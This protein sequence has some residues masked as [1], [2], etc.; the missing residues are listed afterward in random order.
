MLLKAIF[1]INRYVLSTADY[2]RVLLVSQISV[3]FIFAMTLFTL[4][5]VVSGYDRPL[6]YNLFAI[7]SG[8]VVLILNRQGYFTSAMVVLTIAVQ[9]V[10]MYFTAV[11]PTELGTYLIAIPINIG[12]LAVYGNDRK[13][14]AVGMLVVSFL[15]YYFLTFHSPFHWTDLEIT[16]GY[17]ER[18]LIVSYVVASIAAVV[19]VYYLMRVN[20][21]VESRLTVK[22]ASLQQRN[23]ELQAANASLDKFF[24][25]VSHDLR[26]PLTSMQGLIQL[27]RMSNDAAELKQ[28]ASM[29]NGR[30]ENLDAFIRKI[31]DY[32]RNSQMAIKTDTINLRSLIRDNLENFRFYPHASSIRVMLEIPDQLMI[33]SDTF[34]LQEVFGN[35][36]SNAFKYYDPGKASFIRIS[37]KLLGDKVQVAI[38]DNGMGIREEELP[39]VFDMFYRAN[40]ST[41]GTGLGLFIVQETLQKLKGKIEVQSKFG[42]GTTFTVMLPITMVT[43]PHE[44]R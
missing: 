43:V 13:W 23:Q 36:I 3:L 37:S 40:R 6:P 38:E 21:Q 16:P 32:S 24:Y 12:I 7:A 39:R 28:Y 19:V 29:L 41:P 5:D 27:M 8:I 31:G 9:T 33:Q 4:V 15:L 30:A 20:R 2:K 14:L 34:R 11:L 35:L 26:A 18:N 10:T 42:K 1:G 22:D 44:I 17:L 25:S